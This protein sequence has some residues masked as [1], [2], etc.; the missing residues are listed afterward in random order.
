MVK[1]VSI[2]ESEWKATQKELTSLREL[3]GQFL[4]LVPSAVALTER[5]EAGAAKASPKA[6]IVGL[7]TKADR[8]NYFREHHNKVKIKKRS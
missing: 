1:M 7:K 3:V 4:A 5:G 8:M 2:P 6:S